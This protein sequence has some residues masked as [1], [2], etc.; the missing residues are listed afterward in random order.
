MH[1]L[2]SFNIYLQPTIDVHIK[3]GNTPILDYI[4]NINTNTL[5][6]LRN[7]NIFFIDQVNTTDGSFLKTWKEL[8]DTHGNKFL[9]KYSITG[10]HFYRILN[11]ISLINDMVLF[12]ILCSLKVGLQEG[13]KIVKM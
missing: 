7:K 11:L 5:T 3:G 2:A 8:L 1:C 6:S 10:A 9:R 4:I 13:G 12:L